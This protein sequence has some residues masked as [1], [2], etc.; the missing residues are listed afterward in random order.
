MV[1]ERG[2]TFL[3]SD[4]VM[5]RIR[6]TK[7]RFGVTPEPPRPARLA[8]APSPVGI[9]GFEPAPAKPPRVQWNL[10]DVDLF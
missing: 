6:S 5:E 8:A 9:T 3:F 4:A 7:S 2:P 1:Y 10:S